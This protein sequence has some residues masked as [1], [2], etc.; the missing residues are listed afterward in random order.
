VRS[1][2]QKRVE[3]FA[4]TKLIVINS[5][6]NVTLS[7]FNFGVAKRNDS[8]GAVSFKPEALVA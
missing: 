7:L 1:G 5:Y 6:H 2:Q 4:A 3:A 8:D